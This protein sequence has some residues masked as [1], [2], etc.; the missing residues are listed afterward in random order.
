MTGYAHQR[1]G[2]KTRENDVCDTVDMMRFFAAVLF[3]APFVAFAQA[4]LS[5]QIRADLLQDPRT[6]Q[7]SEAELNALV[8]ALADE[9]ESTGEADTYLDAKTAPTFTY[10]PPPVGT[11]TAFEAIVSAP[12][13]I[14][15]SALLAGVAFLVLI[16][17]RK[18]RGS[19]VSASAPIPPP[20]S[21]GPPVS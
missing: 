18:R 1:P 14:A 3:L 15:L 10:D 5:E 13:V 12:I 16:M 6:A 9:A 19:A 7:L 21:G 17:M 11:E 8:A 2:R 4:S 20:A